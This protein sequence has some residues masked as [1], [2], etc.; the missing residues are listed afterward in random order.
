MSKKW[1]PSLFEGPEGGGAWLERPPLDPLPHLKEEIARTM[2][3]SPYSRP[4]IVERMNL[5]MKLAGLA[6]RLSLARLDAWAAK[7]KTALPDLQEA[8]FFYWAA[9]SRV[10]LAGQAQRAGAAL[11]TPEDRKFLELGKAEHK[12]R[13]LGR[14]ARRLRQEIEEKT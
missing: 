12:L 10:V 5:A 2:K 6:G 4:Q 14:K 8:E 7:S 13:E 11:V 1:Q 9:G 3:A